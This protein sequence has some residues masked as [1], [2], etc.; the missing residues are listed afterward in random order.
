MIAVTN[1]NE[2]AETALPFF[3]G[4]KNKFFQFKTRRSTISG[5]PT[6]SIEVCIRL[7]LSL[8]EE[9]EAVFIDREAEN[10]YKVITVVNPRDASLREQIYAREEEIMAAYP[11]M[12][13][14]FHVLARMNRRLDDIITKAH[15]VIF[16]R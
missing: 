5:K 2:Q 11:T 1:W 14:D 9:V 10:Q 15:G 4:D 6:F 3:T 16:S 12:R 7:E 8:V 13:F